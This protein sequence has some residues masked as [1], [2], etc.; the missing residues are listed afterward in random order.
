MHPVDRYEFF[1]E[2]VRDTIVIDARAGNSR[3]DLVILGYSP[4]K[5]GELLSNNT[6]PVCIHAELED[7]VRKN[8]RRPLNSVNLGHQRAVDKAS[9]IK[10]LVTEI[11]MPML[12]NG[13]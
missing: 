3:D 1:G 4:Q 10:D 6:P 5:L 9:L 2:A 13:H 8:G 7:W 12:E 11:S